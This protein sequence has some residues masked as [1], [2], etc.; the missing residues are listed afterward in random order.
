M[1]ATT[2]GR[3]NINENDNDLKLKKYIDYILK[4]YIDGTKNSNSSQGN[5][6]ESNNTICYFLKNII[7]FKI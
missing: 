5:S 2:K 6:I 3:Q 1:K 4:K 7:P